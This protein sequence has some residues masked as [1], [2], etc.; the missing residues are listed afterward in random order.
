M[1]EGAVAVAEPW[2][3]RSTEVMVSMEDNNWAWFLA[4]AWLGSLGLSFLAGIWFSLSCMPRLC[5]VNQRMG[6][7]LQALHQWWQGVVEFHKEIWEDE[8]KGQAGAGG[9]RGLPLSPMRPPTS[10]ATSPT[11]G[12]SDRTN[13]TT[14][15]SVDS[16]KARKGV[17][18]RHRR[19][20]SPNERPNPVTSRSERWQRGPEPKLMREAILQKMNEAASPWRRRSRRTRQ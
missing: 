20:R 1:K 18:R 9:E 10:I 15:E 19:P 17:G 2:N 11:A 13:W 8:M 12:N 5:Q 4:L 7:Q 14:E 3:P 16:I 6:G